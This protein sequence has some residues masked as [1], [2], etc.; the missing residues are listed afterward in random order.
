MT[1]WGWTGPFGMAAQFTR[2][3]PK[4]ATSIKRLNMTGSSSLFIRIRYLDQARFIPKSP[5]S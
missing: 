5:G 2:K 4:I 1:S 3:T